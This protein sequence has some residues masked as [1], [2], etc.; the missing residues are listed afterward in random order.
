VGHPAFTEIGVSH[1][2]L[3]KRMKKDSPSSGTANELCRAGKFLEALDQFKV[4]EFQSA[5][6]SERAGYL[7]DQATCYHEIG[8][9]SA[10]E[11]CIAKAKELVSDDPLGLAQI[12]YVTAVFLIEE[13]KREL[14]LQVL[15]RIVRNYPAQFESKDARK[16]YERVQVQRAF[17]LMH[18]SKSD[19]ARPLFEE[20][21]SFELERETECLVHCHLGHCYHEL[22]QYP[23]SRDQFVLAETLGVPEDWEAT[24]H[25]YFG[26]T[27]FKLNDYASARRHFIMCLQ[28]GVPGPPQSFVYRMLAD[29]CR[30]LGE[31]RQATLYDKM[32]RSS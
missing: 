31:R 28:S 11:V 13:G 6:L 22:S 29:T 7:V 21:L 8:N 16:L 1:A 20:A 3:A 17:T 26:Y 24:F 30:K 32:A 5:D 4:L 25:Y 18:L 19:E 14:G 12:E 27:V 2:I 10:T 23:S 9:L 15:S